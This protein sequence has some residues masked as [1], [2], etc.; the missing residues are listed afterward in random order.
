MEVEIWKD[1]PG[2]EGLYQVSSHGNVKSLDRYIYHKK[3]KTNRFYKGSVKHL[4]K[5]TEGY[6]MVGLSKGKGVVKT[7]NVH[8]LVAISFFN[9][10]S[11]NVVNHIDGNKL[12]NKL[13][14]LEIV[15]HRENLCHAVDYNKKRSKYIGVSV[16][17]YK[18]DFRKWVASISVNGKKIHLGY[19]EDEEEA[20]EA[21]KKALEDNNLENKYM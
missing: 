21:Y 12:N 5:N 19:F 4:R 3:N 18:G 6:L 11:L 14:N 7:Y 1:I 9:I 8:R 10:N 20:Y 16:K 17:C 13:N 2:Y 15:N